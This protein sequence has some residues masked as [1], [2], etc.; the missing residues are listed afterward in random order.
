[1]YEYPT[2]LIFFNVVNK[3]DIGH[4]IKELRQALGLKQADFARALSISRPSLSQIENGE[5]GPSLDLIHHIVLKYDI[6]YDYLLDGKLSPPIPPEFIP[7]KLK[8]QEGDKTLTIHDFNEYKSAWKM[9]IKKYEERIASL[10]G[11]IHNLM[12]LL[13]KKEQE[14]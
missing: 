2:F 11:D 7:E 8:Q 12:S 9:L 3:H 10:E 1:M 14:N 4:R 6:S 5:V 13:S